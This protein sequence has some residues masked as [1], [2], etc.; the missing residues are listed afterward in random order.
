MALQL[1]LNIVVCCTIYVSLLL[2][3]ISGFGKIELLQWYLLKVVIL[4]LR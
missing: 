2:K 1:V 3:N 4:I